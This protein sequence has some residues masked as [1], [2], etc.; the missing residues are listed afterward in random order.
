MRIHADTFIS[1]VLGRLGESPSPASA[2]AGEAEGLSLSALIR[3]LAPEG[4]TKAIMES[5]PAMLDD[6]SFFGESVGLSEQGLG[7]V[8][9]PD[10]FLR[11]ASFRMDCWTCALSEPA[12]PASADW[13]MMDS[14]CLPLRGS[15]RSPRCR[16]VQRGV[17]RVLEFAPLPTGKSH[18]AEAIYVARPEFDSEGYM[19]L[20]AASLPAA[21]RNTAEGVASLIS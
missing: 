10:D 19:R 17:G 16:I 21:V 3:S 18:V 15:L 14:P 12:T 1:L 9:L 11:L 7:Y 20:P 5:D 4:A 6:F 13:R 8:M 2:F